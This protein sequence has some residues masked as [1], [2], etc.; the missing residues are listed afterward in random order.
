M[1]TGAS[2]GIG[3]QLA[4]DMTK[5]GATVIISARRTDLLNEV[6]N[7]AS[8]YGEKPTVINCDMLNHESQKNAYKSVKKS[9]GTIDVLILAAGR[10]QRGLAIETPLSIHE[11]LMKLNYFSFIS[12]TNLLLP[13]MIER[14]SGHVS[15]SLSLTNHRYNLYRCI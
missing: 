4:I 12:L 3:R 14:K 2:S 10:G 7:E 9:F 15:I 6:A 11:D 8:K 5:A 1:C 13:D